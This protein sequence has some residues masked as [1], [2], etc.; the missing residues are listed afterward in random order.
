MLR[1]D[2]ELLSLSVEGVLVTLLTLK[3]TGLLAVLLR[4]AQL[5]ALARLVAVVLA[6][7]KIHRQA[8]VERLVAQGNTLSQRVALAD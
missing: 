6:N 7:S 3:V 8:L 5:A 2:Q 4:L 1:R